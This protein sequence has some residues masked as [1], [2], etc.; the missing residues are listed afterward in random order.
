LVLLTLL[1]SGQFLEEAR[2]VFQSA[3]DRFAEFL[4]TSVQKS[5]FVLSEVERE[6]LNSTLE[7]YRPGQSKPILVGGNKVIKP[8]LRLMIDYRLVIEE[9]KDAEVITGYTRMGGCRVSEGSARSGSISNIQSALRAQSQKGSFSRRFGYRPSD[10][11]RST[12]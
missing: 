12:A 10:R 5:Y 11:Y 3:L 1:A 8:A 9:I 4:P 6:V 7:K 2:L